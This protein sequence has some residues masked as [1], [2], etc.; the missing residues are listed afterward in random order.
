MTSLAHSNCKINNYKQIKEHRGLPAILQEVLVVMVSILWIMTHHQVILQLI[1]IPR[2]Q[3]VRQ[4]VVLQIKVHLPTIN[5]Q[6][7]VPEIVEN[8]EALVR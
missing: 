8:V 2:Q 1:V 4:I 5:L 3:E 6:G 7:Q